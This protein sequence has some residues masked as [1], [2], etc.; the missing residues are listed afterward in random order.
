MARVVRGA[1]RG[2]TDPLQL[3]RP[4]GAA[5]AF[6]GLDRCLPLMHGSQGCAAFAKA[7]LT[8]H[9][10]EPIPLQTTAVTELTA[11]LGSGGHLVSALDTVRRA[12]AP[13]V[14]GVITTGVSEASGEDVDATVRDYLRERGTGPG[15]PLV[16]LVHAPD[17][18]G[19]LSDGWSGA[20]AAIVGAGLALDAAPPPGPVLPVL[21]GV[22]LTAAGLDEISAVVSGF[23]LQP[24][25]VP[26][27]SRSL[28]GHLDAAWSPLTTGGTTRAGLAALRHAPAGLALGSTAAA[29][30]AALAGGGVP[31][32]RF[33]HLAGLDA[34]DA[35]VEHLR[36]LTSRPV[37]ERVLRDRA[38]LADGMIDTHVVLGGARVAI[39]AEAELLVAVSHLLAGAGATVVAAVAPTDEPVLRS[40]A[41]AEVVIGD[42]GDLR[43]RAAEAG[44][45]VVVASSH[46]VAT[47]V[48]TGA[49]HVPVGLPVDHRFGAALGGVT[50]YRGG[51]RFLF[52][53][54]NEVLSH[55][56]ATHAAVHRP[57]DGA[58]T[59][60]PV[61]A[62][63]RRLPC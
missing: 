55:R 38:R 59:P 22:T 25:L 27:L 43:E 21:A 7:L 18:A 51:L 54:A 53:L 9:F 36:A 10:R 13:D 24:L 42:H 44:A 62:P 58:G 35:V 2:T 26:D 56:A 6:L 15:S 49:A 20:L 47:A 30:A 46:G 57:A 60:L 11:V 34:V 33:D 45:E 17:F 52:D 4:L 29:G 8:R 63:A 50:G 32:A 40:A 5:L 41:C 12:S 1:R 37:P 28:D 3:S 23:G 19:G 16:V 48:A 39:A 31:V 61:H 14:V